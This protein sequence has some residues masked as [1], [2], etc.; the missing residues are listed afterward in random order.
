MSEE[1]KEAIKIFNNY[2]NAIETFGTID[3]KCCNNLYESAIALLNLIQKQQ[4]ELEKKDKMINNMAH[5]CSICTG[6]YEN[7]EDKEIIE[8]FTKKVEEDKQ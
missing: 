2:I 8:Y 6:R 1:E 5:E 4:A 7:M 3:P